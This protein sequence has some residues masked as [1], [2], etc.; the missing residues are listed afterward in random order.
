[1]LWRY[2]KS[3]APL[4]AQVANEAMMMLASRPVCSVVIDVVST[5][6][7]LKGHSHCAQ[8]GAVLRSASQ[9][10]AVLRCTA[11]RRCN[12]TRANQ[13]EHSHRTRSKAVPRS[14]EQQKSKRERLEQQKR[15]SSCAVL[16]STSQYCAALRSLCSHMTS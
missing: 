2:F 12:R 1:M 15:R 10:C 3:C 5:E 9:Y 8:Y 16:R 6:E 11:S 7:S 13:R 4:F 14:A